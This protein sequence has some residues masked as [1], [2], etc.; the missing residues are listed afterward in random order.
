MTVLIVGASVAGIRTA[1]ALRTAGYA[2]TITVLGQEPSWPYDK[3]PLSKELLHHG[4]AAGHVPLVTRDQL[5]RLGVE[6]RLGTKA[7]AVDPEARTVTTADD[8]VVGYERLVIATGS[9]PRTLPQVPARSGVYTLRTAADADALRAE[10]ERGARAVVIGAGFIGAEFASAARSRGL[11]VTVLE[12][13]PV[14]MAQVL[15]PEVGGVLA[16]LH[17]ANGTELHT[18]VQV[19]GVAEAE[20]GHVRGVRLADGRVLPADVVLVGVGARPATDWLIGSGLP[21][22]DGICCDSELRVAGFE[23]IWAAGDVARFRHR[24]YEQDLRIEHWTNANE[25]AAIVAAS[26]TGTAPPAPTVPYVWSD[27]YGHRIQ[28]VGRPALGSLA[29]MAGSLRPGGSF[30]AVYA[31]AAGVLVGGLVIDDTKLFMK[32]RRAVTRRLVVDAVALDAAIGA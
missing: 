8:A 19:T 7:V 25:H 1:Q 31:N 11:P 3:P 2:G 28:I 32:V 16:G 14:A 30:A 27:Q 15:G 10:L 18:T 23:D 20:G 5:A 9:V 6:L 21:V 12:A 29:A 4:L 26:I 22:Q 17:V 13:Q 24:L